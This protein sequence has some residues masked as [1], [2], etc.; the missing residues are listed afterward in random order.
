MSFF[1][2]SPQGST[3][4]SSR[5]DLLNKIRGQKIHFPDFAA[6][7]KHW[8]QSRSDHQAAWEAKVAAKAAEMSDSEDMREVLCKTDSPMFVTIW[9]P[10]A[11]LEVGDALVTL[12]LWVS[13]GLRDVEIY[14]LGS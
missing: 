10:D 4:I 8:P 14:E 6:L 1:G 2:K 5:K 3:T 13:S 11:S 9:W 12:I 7:F